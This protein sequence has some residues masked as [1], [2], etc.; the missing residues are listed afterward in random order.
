V[1]V[2]L[3]FAVFYKSIF[4]AYI[5]SLS[6]ESSLNILMNH[7]DAYEL[8]PFFCGVLLT[9]LGVFPLFFGK[10]HGLLMRDC[11]LIN[12]FCAF[13]PPAKLIGA[14][15]LFFLPFLDVQC[16]YKMQ[17]ARNPERTVIIRQSGMQIATGHYEDRVPM[18]PSD[19]ANTKEGALAKAPAHAPLVAVYGAAIALGVLAGLTLRPG[20][21]RLVLLGV[22]CVGALCLLLVQTQNGFPLA[23]SVAAENKALHADPQFAKK[24][25][26]LEGPPEL[27][28]QQTYWYYGALI[29]PAAALFA[30]GLDWFVN[31]E[32]LPSITI[33]PLLALGQDTSAAD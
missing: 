2:G 23:S 27:M 19:Y 13:A 12:R 9:L 18:L 17:A 3:L 22:C 4:Q 15:F 32:R 26:L 24:D 6:P 29:L 10:R 25:S 16:Q 20:W 5:D 8:T 33:A 7:R 31:R 1:I 21:M 14:A 30:A 11:Q 28:L